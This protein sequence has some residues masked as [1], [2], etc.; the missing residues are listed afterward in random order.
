MKDHKLHTSER[1][2]LINC[3]PALKSD[4]YSEYWRRIQLFDSCYFSSFKI[5]ATYLFFV[6]ITMFIT[7]FLLFI[8]F[9]WQCLCCFYNNTLILLYIFAFVVKLIDTWEVVFRKQEPAEW[10]KW[11]HDE[12]S[13]SQI[14]P[15]NNSTNI[16]KEFIFLTGLLPWVVVHTH[17]P[18]SVVLTFR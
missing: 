9:V 4:V 8:C 16:Y 11:L 10:Y 6:K 1:F 5:N 7:L 15:L 17:R 3:S 18:R 12:K 13:T 14:A 2:Y